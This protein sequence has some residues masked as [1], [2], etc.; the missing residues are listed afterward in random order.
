MAQNGDNNHSGQHSNHDHHPHGDIP[1]SPSHFGF[2]GSFLAEDLHELLGAIREEHEVSVVASHFPGSFSQNSSVAAGGSNSLSH[3]PHQDRRRES[4]S[5]PLPG[6]PDKAQARS[7]RKRSRERQRR[8]DVNKQFSDLTELMRKIEAEDLASDG[9]KSSGGGPST[10]S[11]T[12]SS[13]RFS[14]SPANRV[15]LIAKTITVLERLHTANQKRKRT[16]RELQEELE[17]TRKAGEDAAARLKQ[18]GTMYSVGG[19][20]NKVCG[21]R[22]SINSCIYAELLSYSYVQFIR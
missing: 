15:D 5:P 3:E 4:T 18:V 13:S 1:P 9:E 22:A 19:N 2:T 11:A 20:N 17:R 10:T 6:D 8:S 21:M 14:F 7:E 16:V 12:A